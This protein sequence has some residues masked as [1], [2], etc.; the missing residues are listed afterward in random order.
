[1]RNPPHR[2][3]LC[4]PDCYQVHYVINPWMEGNIERSSQA[5]AAEQW[6]SL[7]S[8]LRE[9]A[10]IELI[11]PVAGSPDM[12]FTANAGLVLGN[13]AVLSRFFHPERQGEEPHFRRWFETHGF[14]LY[15]LPQDLPFEGAGDAL[16]DRLQPWLWA[17]YGFRSELDSHTYLSRWLDIEIVS[18]RLLDPRFYHLDTCFC[19]LENGT[20][21]YYPPAFDAYSNRLIEQRVPAEKR[22]VLAEPDALR[23]ACNAVN[24]GQCIVLNQASDG[25]KAQLA[26]HGFRVVETPLCEFI[27]AGGAAKCLTL[28]L[29]EPVPA[30]LAVAVPEVATAIESRVIEIN[31]HLLDTGLVNRALDLVTDGGGSFQV[32]DF[33]LGAQKQSTSEA[34]IRV[35]AP[36]ANVLEPILRG[37]IELGATAPEDQAADARLETVIQ[38]GVAPDDFYVTTIYPTEIRVGG[39]WRRCERQRMDGAVVLEKTAGSLGEARDGDGEHL[40]PVCKI[41]RDLRVGDQVVVGVEGI[42]TARRM[43]SR[44]VPG[45]GAGREEFTFMGSGVSSERRVELVVEQIAWELR[46]IRD[47]GGRVVVTAGP[48]VVHTGG[49]PHLAR[50]V[51]EGYVQTLLAGNAIAVH[52]I[53]QAMLGTSLGMDLQ[54]GVSVHGGHRHHLKVINTV[55]RHGSIAAAVDAGVIRS[56]VMFE[57]VKNGVPFVLAGSI[58]DDGPLP[59]TEMDLIRAQSRYAEE[60]RGA[61]MVL[62]LSSMLH[63]IGVGNMTPAG[64]RLVCVDINPAVVTKLADRG[65]VESVGVVT[66]VGLFL[67]LLLQQ[68]EKLGS[69]FQQ[70]PSGGNFPAFPS[71]SR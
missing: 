67:S 52:D 24:V 12:V 22:I 2:F 3:L 38:D 1:M 26:E 10:E 31:G 9:L 64:V 57:C 33:K 48:V 45:A 66:D 71:R 49:A 56:G 70:Q 44:E 43:D 46:Q 61:D 34:R 30:A 65:S 13:K 68:L 42:R 8:V 25:L 28:R 16:R 50:L 6:N 37:L 7:H 14:R 39:Q 5:R 54:R 69:P 27:K 20:L 21:L 40:V 19:P 59:D 60:I 62:M 4:Q 41:L 36:S 53:E 58:R 51:R 18:L 11:Q 55:R 32:L 29:D 15:E 23:F 17:G 47:R 63:S 35:L